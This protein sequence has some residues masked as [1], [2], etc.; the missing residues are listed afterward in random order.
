MSLRRG[1]YFVVQ[2]FY[3]NWITHFEW[4]N[5]GILSFFTY[6]HTDTHTH[7]QFLSLRLQVTNMDRIERI[8]AH[9]TWF[10]VQMCLSGVLTMI[11]YFYLGVQTPKNENL[12]A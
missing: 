5:R 9:S 3:R 12:G 8:N 6:K 7:K 2:N 4:A 10:Q 11:N 1:V